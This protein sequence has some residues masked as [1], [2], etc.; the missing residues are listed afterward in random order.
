MLFQ[1]PVLAEVRPLDKT[2]NSSG[3]RC[4]LVD[5]APEIS[6]GSVADDPYPPL[7]SKLLR[8]YAATGIT[9]AYIVKENGGDDDAR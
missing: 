8:D 5:L 4:T 7:L 1:M 2:G 3:K 6:S 9:P